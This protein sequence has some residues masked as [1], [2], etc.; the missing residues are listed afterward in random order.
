MTSRIIHPVRIGCAGWN[1]PKADA[2]EFSLDGSHLQRYSSRFNCVEINSSFY[3]S[4]QPSTYARWAEC[5]PTTFRFSVKL[6]RR[7][8]HDLRLVGVGGLLDAFFA[9]VDMLGQKLGCVLVQLPPSFRF[10]RAVVNRFLQ[11]LRRRHAGDVVLEPRH[12]SWFETEA[13]DVLK[14]FSIGR[15]AAD[16]AVVPAAALPGGDTRVVYLRLHGSPKIYYSTYPQARLVEIAESLHNAVAAGARA[17]CVFD[18][19]ALGAATANALETTRLV[20]KL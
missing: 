15:V 1:V 19:T 7:I 16:P 14:H 20:E 2:S 3:K 17:W 5:V 11:M 13:D 9:E 18:N 6:P 4:H 12:A 8:T 10:E